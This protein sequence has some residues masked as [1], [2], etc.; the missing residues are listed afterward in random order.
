VVGWPPDRLLT[1]SECEC[2]LEILAALTGAVRRY[3]Q[4]ADVEELVGENPI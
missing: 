4:F 3:K 2:L 1:G